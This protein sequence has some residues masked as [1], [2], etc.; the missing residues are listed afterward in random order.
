[1]RVIFFVIWLVEN[2]VA[3]WAACWILNPEVQV[4]VH[5][6]FLLFLRGLKFNL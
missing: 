6:Y 5:N 4:Q 2:V 3:E 1:M